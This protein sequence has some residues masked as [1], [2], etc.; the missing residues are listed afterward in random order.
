MN[1]K[2]GQLT[3]P[4]NNKKLRDTWVIQETYEKAMREFHII[5]SKRTSLMGLFLWDMRSHPKM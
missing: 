4:F 1:S 2:A 5:D 3:S